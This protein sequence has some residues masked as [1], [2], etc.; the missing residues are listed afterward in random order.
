ML[1]KNLR[2]HSALLGAGIVALV[3]AG[4][5]TPKET[6]NAVSKL[7]AREGAS[8]EETRGLNAP[9]G[10]YIHGEHIAQSLGAWAANAH[11]VVRELNSLA[12]KLRDSGTKAEDKVSPQTL[13]AIKAQLQEMLVR[14]VDIRLTVPEWQLNSA[15]S[16][17][18]ALVAAYKALPTAYAGVFEENITFTGSIKVAIELDPEMY[19]TKKDCETELR[20]YAAETQEPFC[21]AHAYS[22]CGHQMDLK[23]LSDLLNSA[24][25]TQK[26]CEHITTDDQ[27]REK[28]TGMSSAW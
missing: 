18:K 6:A 24:A 8:F 14:V 25:R 4:C 22:V 19:D 27:G 10:T 21:R 3:A 15:Q 11:E 12:D 5:P 28:K 16:S 20:I 2:R 9:S 26:K 7:I 13:N 1:L 17:L 23:C